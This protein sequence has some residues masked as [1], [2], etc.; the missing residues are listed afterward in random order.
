MS[1]TKRGRSSAFVLTVLGSNDSN[2]PTS[3]VGFGGPDCKVFQEIM[4]CSV[5]QVSL[6]MAGSE[7]LSKARIRGPN[8]QIVADVHIVTGMVVDARC[9]DYMRFIRKKWVMYPASRVVG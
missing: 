1:K 6:S 4:N 2:A 5:A 8:I 9:I 3:T 7:W